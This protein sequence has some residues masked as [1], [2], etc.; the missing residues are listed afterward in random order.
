MNHKVMVCWAPLYHTGLPPAWVQ[1]GKAALE[2][3]ALGAIS[4]ATRWCSEAGSIS[5]I[6]ALSDRGGALQ[7]GAAGVSCKAKL[8]VLQ[9]GQTPALQLTDQGRLLKGHI[10]TH[11]TVSMTLWH[12]YLKEQLLTEVAPFSTFCKFW[13]VLLIVIK[14]T[15][16][17]HHCKNQVNGSV[18]TPQWWHLS[19]TAEPVCVSVPVSV[20]CLFSA[21]SLSCRVRCSILCRHSVLSADTLSNVILSRARI[22][23]EIHTPGNMTAVVKLFTSTIPLVVLHFLFNSA[24]TTFWCCMFVPF[25]FNHSTVH[26]H[27]ISPRNR[28]S[29]LVSTFIQLYVHK[30]TWDFISLPCSTL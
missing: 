2:L 21:S 8:H 4:L 20:T 9:L 15:I 7:L 17:P 26:M 1:E 5:F 14:N 16:F 30:F 29:L 18:P 19:S 3:H 27:R 12:I 10:Q 13:R 24:I 22:W 11:T 28:R 25:L 23:W 6:Q